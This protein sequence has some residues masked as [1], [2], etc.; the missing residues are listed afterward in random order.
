MVIPR[1]GGEHLIP[2][3]IEG[4]VVLSLFFALFFDFFQR[5]RVGGE[6]KRMDNV[7][8]V[9]NGKSEVGVGQKLLRKVEDKTLSVFMPGETDRRGGIDGDIE[10]SSEA[11]FDN[12]GETDD[13]FSIC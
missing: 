11:I 6:S 7:F 12:I 10:V 5:V 9:I 13:D 4:D 8:F 2:G 1:C 3:K